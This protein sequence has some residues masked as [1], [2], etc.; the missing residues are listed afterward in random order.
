[1][2]EKKNN[3]IRGGIRKITSLPAQFS[4]PSGWVDQEGILGEHCNI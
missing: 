2:W 4:S 1:M 3:E